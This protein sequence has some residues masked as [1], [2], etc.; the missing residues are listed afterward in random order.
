MVL[1]F[2]SILFSVSAVLIKLH[3][4]FFF[5]FQPFIFLSC[6]NLLLAGSFSPTSD[7]NNP[8]TRRSSEERTSSYH[9]SIE[10]SNDN[11]ND[12]TFQKNSLTKDS[13]SFLSVTSALNSLGFHHQLSSSGCFGSNCRFEPSSSFTNFGTA[14]PI[15]RKQ[16]SSQFTPD[17]SSILGISG[18]PL[19][20]PT[21]AIKTSSPGFIIMAD[22]ITTTMA[23]QQRLKKKR[24]KKRRKK[25]EEEEKEE[26]EKQEEREEN[27]YGMGGGSKNGDNSSIYN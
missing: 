16:A 3:D 23:S 6:F 26:K 24:N 9:T 20:S 2:F 8:M 12:V 7:I 27:N 15:P 21:S 1:S 17:S 10:I 11:F 14:I 25:E 5:P 13:S 4:C 19:P 18:S 22:A